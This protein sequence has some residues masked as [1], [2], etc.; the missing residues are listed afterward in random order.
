VKLIAGVDEV[1]RGPLAGPV[2][3]AAVIL[4]P[5]NPIIGLRDSKKLSEKKREV[6]NT[7]IQNQAASFSFGRA[8][9]HEIDQLNILHASLLAMQRAI[10][11]LDIQPDHALIDG[12]HAPAL[13]CE[14]TTIIKGDDKEDAIA[15]ASIIAKVKRDREMLELHQQFPNYGFDRHKGYPTKYHLQALQEYGVTQHHRRSFRPVKDIL[16]IR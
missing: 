4:D 1:G 16:T 9:V 7:I 10:D 5:D 14:V 6:L 13:D 12:N 3:A 8:E 11:A 15:A 2:I